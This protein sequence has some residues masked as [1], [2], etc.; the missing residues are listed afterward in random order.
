[1]VEVPVYNMSGEQT[2]TMEVDEAAFGTTVNAPL[3][4]QAVVAY[5]ANRAR[6]TAATKSRAMVRGAGQKLFRQK[7][8]GRARRGTIRTNVLRGG[9]VAFAKRPRTPGKKLPR[10]MRRAAVRSAICAKLLGGDLGVVDDVRLDAPKTAA[11]AGMLRGIGIDRTCLLVLAA[12]DAT[13]QLSA[14]NL[15]DLAVRTIVEL[16]AYEVATRRKLLVTRAAMDAL[17]SGEQPAGVGQE[18]EA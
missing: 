16:N 1:M 14:R 10:K 13:V 4:K 12:R 7:G 6:R 18:V 9:G 8:T 17:V 15:A 11:L 2:G 5:Q 3:L